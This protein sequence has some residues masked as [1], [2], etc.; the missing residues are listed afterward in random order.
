MIDSHCHLYE[1]DESE[2]VNSG[3]EAMICAG[4]DVESSRMAIK[5]ANKYDC[6][7]ATVGMHPESG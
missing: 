7:W 2:W 6:V 1:L 3:L 4:A 5:L